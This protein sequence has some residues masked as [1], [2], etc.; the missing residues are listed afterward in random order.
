Y[1]QENGETVDTFQFASGARFYFGFEPEGWQPESS[2]SWLVYGGAWPWHRGRFNVLYF[3]G[4]AKNISL[5]QLLEG[6]DFRPGWE[7]LITSLE[8]YRWDLSQ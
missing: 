5:G 3:D 2:H 8:D 6:C 4:S 7:G 1:T